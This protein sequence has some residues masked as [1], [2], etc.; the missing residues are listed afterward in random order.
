VPPALCVT[1]ITS[2]GIVYD[3]FP[4]LAPR[5]A[6]G[7]GWSTTA[8]TAA[9]SI[10]LLVSATAELANHLGRRGT[11]AALAR[12]SPQSPS[13]PGPGPAR[14]LA[15]RPTTHHTARASDATARTRPF[16][17]LT[18]ALTLSGFAVHAVVIGLVPGGTLASRCPAGPAGVSLSRRVGP[19][20]TESAQ[21][22]AVGGDAEDAGARTC[23]R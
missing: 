4:V 13:R 6:V 10:A 8:T 16:L 3:A 15:T 23:S 7:T 9:F 14:L 18:A 17:M 21:C 5:I 19:R 20:R 22:G 11:Y 12:S 1:Q 2:W